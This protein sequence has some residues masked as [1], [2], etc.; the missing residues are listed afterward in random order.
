MQANGILGR[1]LSPFLSQDSEQPL[2]KRRSVWLLR[3][4]IALGMIALLHYYSWWFI[5]GRIASPWLVLALAAAILYSGTQLLGSWLLYLAACPQSVPPPPPDDLTVDVF[6][7]ACGESHALIERTLAAACAMRGNH[8]TWLLDDAADPALVHLAERLGA[9]YLVRT[10]RKDAKAGNINA[11]LSRTS[12][13]IVVIFDI[14]HTPAVDFLERAV[15]HFVDPT[16]GFVQVM[17]TFSNNKESWVAQAAAESSLDFYNPTSIGTGR[18]SSATLMGSNALIRR[19]ALDSIGGYQPGLA[20]DLATSIALH[21]AGW[22]SAY[23]AEP[24][25]PGL[26]PPDLAA[27]FT[28]QLKWARGV[29]ELLLTVYPRSFARLTWSQRLSY[30][31]RMTCYWIGPVVCIHLLLTLAILMGGSSIARAGFQQYLDHLLPLALSTLVIRQVALGTWRHSSTLTG[32]LWRAVTLVYTTWPIY[33]L[34]WVMALLRLPLAFRLTPKSPTGVLHPFWLLP[35]GVI[36]LLLGSGM[37]Y[38]L[39]TVGEYL[40]LL[41]ICFATFQGV[42]QAALLGQWLHSE[43]GFKRRRYG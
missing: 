36:L 23:V 37:L 39:V 13:D 28:Q 15:G 26:A 12:G 31:V 35:Q 41:L 9:G 5:G 24:L 10:G 25:A 14:D 40:S 43:S 4:L 21:A 18:I 32:P 22:R 8:R 6:V 33:T 11:A 30:A 3:G 19:T 7:T 20:E 42:P 34:A 29:F 1:G 17:L 38:S 2:G 16:V 27:W